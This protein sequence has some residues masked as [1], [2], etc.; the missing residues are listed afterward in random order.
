M[1]CLNIEFV[2][3]KTKKKIKKHS[4]H[5]VYFFFISPFYANTKTKTLVIRN[6]IKQNTPKTTK[7]QQI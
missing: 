2:L 3:S 6:N 1:E 5:C 7:K 4:L